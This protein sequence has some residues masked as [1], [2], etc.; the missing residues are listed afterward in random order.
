[1]RKQNAVPVVAMVL[2]ALAITSCGGDSSPLPT[3]PPPAAPESSPPASS[4]WVGAGRPIVVSGCD[5]YAGGQVLS[6]VRWRLGWAGSEIG[7]YDSRAR[8]DYEGTLE[9]LRFAAS[10]RDSLTQGVVG[11]LTGEFAADFSYF[12]ATEVLET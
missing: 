2:A 4:D 7:L 1:M 11:T 8:R 6:I 3:A 9:G 12:E 10:T 5:E